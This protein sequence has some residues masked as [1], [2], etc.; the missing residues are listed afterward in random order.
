[1]KYYYDKPYSHL[2]PFIMRAALKVMH[3]MLL[4]WLT[5]EA[6]SSHTLH[7]VAVPERAREGQSDKMASDLEVRLKQKCVTEFL[8][9]GTITPT[10]IH[11]CS[12]SISEDQTAGVSTAVGSAFQQ[13]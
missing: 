11:L 13:W 12:L 1:M 3:S 7:F 4:C 2:I 10:D 6:E 8:H 9:G 5:I